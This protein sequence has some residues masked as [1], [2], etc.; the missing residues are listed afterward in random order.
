M[1]K[2]FG[3]CLILAVLIFA[4]IAAL[5]S[6]K[7]AAGGMVHFVTSFEAEASA[8]GMGFSSPGGVDLD[9][10]FINRT[11]L[12][13]S[14]CVQFPADIPG[15]AGIPNLCPGTENDRRWPEPGEIVTFTAHVINKGTIGSPAFDSAWWIDG[16]EVARG[17]LP[18]LAAAQEVTATYRW[19]WGHELSPDG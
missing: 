12:H 2:Y 11:P 9:V 13:H 5:A 1:N 18:A 10:T 16:A 4:F 17:T 3:V 14:Y 6:F 19:P 8:P 7:L 15:Q